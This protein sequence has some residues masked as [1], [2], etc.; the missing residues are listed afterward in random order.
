MADRFWL[1]GNWNDSNNWSATSNGAGGASVPTSA[2][3]VYWHT[4]PVSSTYTINVAANCLDMDWS[5]AANSP[6]FV[7][8]GGNALSVYGSL[9]LISAMTMFTNGT[10]Y[11]DGTSAGK[12]LT[13]AGKALPYLSFRGANGGW[14]LQDDLTAD[15]GISHT[16]G[17][18]NTNGKAVGCSTFSCNGTSTRTLTLGAS[19][20]TCS[21]NVTFTVTGLTLTANTATIVMTGDSKTFAGGGVTSF[22][23]LSITGNLISLT[24]SNTFHNLVVKA[25]N[26]LTATS[27]TTQTATDFKSDTGGSAANFSCASGVVTVTGAAIQDI[28]AGGGATFNAINCEDVSGNSGWEWVV[29]TGGFMTCRSKFW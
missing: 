20:I 10:I 5:G 12:T 3:N 28:A 21:S 23:D 18:L 2:D 25:G 27:G 11:F 22:C 26:T 1:G 8:S 14:T 19:V 7:N 29:V 17:T 4:V 6:N 15:V 16:K 13:S 24:G 9:T